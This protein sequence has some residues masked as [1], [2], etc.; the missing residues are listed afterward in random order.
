M[1]RVAIPRFAPPFLLRIVGK[2]ILSWGFSCSDNID[3]GLGCFSPSCLLQ[4]SQRLGKTSARP[5]F[6]SSDYIARQ[7]NQAIVLGPGT[8][9]SCLVA[10]EDFYGVI[11]YIH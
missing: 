1:G 8:D 4:A 6:Q 3:L 10:N 2:Q 9:D 11:L 7:Q 5:G